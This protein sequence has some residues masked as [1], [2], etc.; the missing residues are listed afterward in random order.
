MTGASVQKDY[1]AQIREILEDQLQG[2]STRKP[3]P[4]SGG[5]TVNINGDRNTVIIGDVSGGRHRDRQ[6]GDDDICQCPLSRELQKLDQLVGRLEHLAFKRALKAA[7]PHGGR[8]HFPCL[9]ARAHR[10]RAHRVSFRHHAPCHPRTSAKAASAGHFI[11]HHPAHPHQIPLVSISMSPHTADGA[12]RAL[13]SGTA[14][15][16]FP[17]YGVAGHHRPETG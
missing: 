1:G 16:R 4:P 14:S 10:R 7:S 13:P 3:E 15:R 17:T 6:G 8:F 12:V 2:P 9:R 11:P 5:V